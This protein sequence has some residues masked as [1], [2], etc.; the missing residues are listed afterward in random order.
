[1]L[2]EK[3]RKRCPDCNTRLEYWKPV[4]EKD[5]Q[6]WYCHK[7]PNLFSTPN[8]L[9]KLDKIAKTMLS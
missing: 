5:I 2:F 8:D 3:Y 1:M 4:N 6:S 9:K 7:C